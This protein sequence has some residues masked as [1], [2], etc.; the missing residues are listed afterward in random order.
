MKKT[1]K[2]VILPTEDKSAPL[3]VDNGGGGLTLNSIEMAYDSTPQ[4]L[5][6]LSDDTI[7]KGDWYIVSFHD[8]HKLEKCI[9]AGQD[10][11]SPRKL[12]HNPKEWCKKIIAT[13]DL[14]LTVE[15]Q[16][17]EHGTGDKIDAKVHIPQIPQS[18]IESYVKNP[19]DEIELEYEQATVNMRELSLTKGK[20]KLL[21]N[22]VVVVEPRTIEVELDGNDIT[23]SVYKKDSNEHYGVSAEELIDMHDKLEEKLYTKEKVESKL[24]EMMNDFGLMSSKE[25]TENFN[26]WVK[27]NL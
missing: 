23:V 25:D 8:D 15:Y 26:R 20:L 21:N 4:H 5:Y 13:T 19:V 24:F 10:I 3:V 12:L 22:A 18:F 16:G 6:I 11:V 17:Y 27:D 7:K 14:K 9:Y 1:H 2:V